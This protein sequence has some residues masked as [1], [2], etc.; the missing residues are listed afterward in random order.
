M[1]PIG[2]ALVL[3]VA[4]LERAA[5][6]TG[7]TDVAVPPG[8]EGARIGVET[9]PL[10]ISSYGETTLLQTTPVAIAVPAGF[11]FPA[12]VEL[13]LRLSGFGAAEAS[14]LAAKAAVAPMAFLGIPRGER[15]TVS[16]VPLRSGSATMVHDL[17]SHDRV[18]RVTLIWSRPGRIFL[19]SGPIADHVA[20]AIAESLNQ[21]P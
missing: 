3:R 18:G 7:L 13:A 17:E 20:I 9:G 15:V 5:V 21:N 8:W 2:G 10:V 14:A 6:T 12:F 4:A 19:L 16:E 1:S 11:D